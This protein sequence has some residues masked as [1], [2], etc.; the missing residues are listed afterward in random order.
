TTGV[1]ES[2]FQAPPAAVLPPVIQ[3]IPDRVTKVGQQVSFLVEASSPQG[4]PVT[5][6]AA[7]LPTGASFT[8]QPADPKSPTV[9]RASFS[10]TPGTGSVG[11]YLINY[12]A[13]DGTL[14]ASRAASIRVE[15][16]V[17]PPGPGTPTIDSPPSGAQV[18]AARPTLQVLT[19]TDAKDPTTKVQFEIYADEAMSKL[20]D[21]GLVDKAANGPGNGAGPVAQ[22]TGWQVGKDLNDNTMY[23]WRARAFNGTTTYSSWVN[24]RL[25]VNIFNDPPDSFN[26][27]SPAADAAVRTFTPTLSWTNSTDKD[28]DAITYGVFVFAPWRGDGGDGSGC[29]MLSGWREVDYHIR[30]VALVEGLPQT[31]GGTTSWTV[32]SPLPEG[33]Y[34]WCVIAKD[35]AGAIT[36]TLTRSFVTKQANYVPSVPVVSSPPVGGQ[37]ATPVT[38]LTVVNSA[39]SDGDP[40]TYVFEIDSVNTFDSA[41]RRISAATAQDKSGSTSWTPPSLV[42]NKRY[43]WRVKAS[44]GK[45]E[46][47]WM[48]SSFLMNERN[49]APPVPTVKNPGN[50]ALASTYPT[51]SVNP[52]EDPEGEAVR[53]EFEVYSDVALT[54]RITS[55]VSNTSSLLVGTALTDKAKYWWRVRAIDASN[56]ASGWSSASMFQASAQFYESPTIELTAPTTIGVPEA[57]MVAEVQRKQVK[58]HWEGLNPSIDRTVALYYS[59]S[60]TGFNGQLIVEGLL[61]KANALTGD[62]IWDVTELGVGAYYVYAVI[63]DGQGLAR[64]YAPGAVVITPEKQANAISPRAWGSPGMWLLSFWV[65]KNPTSEVIFPLVSSKPRIANALPAA[66]AFQRGEAWDVIKGAQIITRANCA[67][68][69]DT[70][71]EITIGKAVS[72]DPEFMGMSV[73][74]PYAADPG[75]AGT[76]SSVTDNPKLWIC[77]PTIVSEKSIDARITEYELRFELTNTGAPISG[78]NAKLVQQQGSGYTVDATRNTLKFG[79]VGSQDVGKTTGVVVVRASKSPIASDVKFQWTVTPASP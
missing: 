3:F 60:K 33:R 68:D 28:G 46:S 29:I 20:V 59:A 65:N 48:V 19:S 40:I 44:D 26:L 78:V 25:F 72:L 9:A 15:S 52:V 16:D 42:E 56:L 21:S 36:A 8:A 76:T 51:L 49:D 37:S 43:W 61:Q 38:K 1:Y 74:V 53:Y 27:A 7:P 22:P 54:Q 5:L 14:S 17:P 12:T 13:T 55:N 24:G 39:D 32:P 47:A 31:P 79:A 73:T 66:I 35:A 63:S 62:Y 50:S 18:K 4:T 71:F 30:V 45:S 11:N 58:V 64:A 70:S 69:G 10:W 6:V 41:D 75:L 34:G 67:A 2:D 57:V 77:S 23:W